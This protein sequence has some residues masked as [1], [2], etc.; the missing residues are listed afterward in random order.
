MQKKKGFTVPRGGSGRWK[1]QEGWGEGT[2]FTSPVHA[3]HSNGGRDTHIFRYKKVTEKRP[4]NYSID[5]CIAYSRGTEQNGASGPSN[6]KSDQSHPTP[7]AC[8]RLI[9]LGSSRGMENMGFQ[10]MSQVASTT[11]QRARNSSS[12]VS[13]AAAILLAKAPR[14]LGPA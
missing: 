2:E 1:G 10:R 7:Q 9:H 4:V 12:R 8:S 13:L 3:E 11:E 14:S 5:C 6:T